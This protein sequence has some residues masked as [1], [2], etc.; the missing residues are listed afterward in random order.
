[1]V[2]ASVDRGSARVIPGEGWAK[3]IPG[4][5]L[6]SV[7]VSSDLLQESIFLALHPHGVKEADLCE[8]PMNCSF[9]I[10]AELYRIFKTDPA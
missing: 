7:L 5:G 9:R 10:S 4:D 2:G 6:M 8:F 3:V 1:M